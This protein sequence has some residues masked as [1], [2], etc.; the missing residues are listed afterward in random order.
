MQ[1]SA[2]QCN[3]ILV[4][5]VYENDVLCCYTKIRFF[6]ASHVV[7]QTQVSFW[8][9]FFSLEIRIYNVVQNNPAISIQSKLKSDV[10]FSGETHY[11]ART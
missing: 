6:R 5:R 3:A 4:P 8:T 2:V 7:Q 11:Q 10:N 1:C 9:N